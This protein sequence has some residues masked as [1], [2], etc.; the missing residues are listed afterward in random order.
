MIGI[1]GNQPEPLQWFVKFFGSSG[2]RASR[3]LIVLDEVKRSGNHFACTYPRG[4]RP[5]GVRDGAIMFMGRLVDDPN[6]I[7]IYGRAIGSKHDHLRDDASEAELALRPWKSRWPHYIRVH[8]AKF[9]DG[10][11]S[12]GVSL[13]EPMA[14]LDWKAFASTSRNHAKNAGNLDPRKSLRQQP[15][16]ELSAD[17]AKWVERRLAEAFEKHG[18]VPAS[19]LENVK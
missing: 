6:D 3:R 5:T 14:T 16:V 18:V 15:A 4:K 9:V 7:I 1:N 13:N 19:S 2:T 10:I 8:D 17:G 12:D 11:L